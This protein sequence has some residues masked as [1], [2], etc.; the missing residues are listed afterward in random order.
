VSNSIAGETVVPGR[1]GW[2]ICVIDWALSR[3]EDHLAREGP[4]LQGA[5]SRK[6]GMTQMEKNRNRASLIGASA[7]VLVLALALITGAAADAKKGKKKHKNP[8][9][10]VSIPLNQ[11]VPVSTPG[12]PGQ[13]GRLTATTTL[14]SAFKKL[15]I[16]DVNAEITASGGDVGGLAV[17]LSAPNGDTVCLLGCQFGLFGK[18]IGPLTLDDETPV[19]LSGAD[20][21]FFQDPD[22]LFSPYVGTAEPE[23]PLSHLDGGP[24]IGTW[25]LRAANADPMNPV[26]ISSWGIHVTTRRPF[27]TK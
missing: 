25:V 6:K 21:A 7:L 24:P 19:I 27:A 17:R 16:D 26:T 12:P 3:L 9:A 13:N 5:R 1:E 18:T 15:R 14:G 11:V 4:G 2:C 22:Q 23:A 8:R 20:P 10:D